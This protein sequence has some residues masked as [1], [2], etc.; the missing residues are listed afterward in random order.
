MWYFVENLGAVLI[1]SSGVENRSGSHH[2][3]CYNEVLGISETTE[4][5]KRCR[6]SIGPRGRDT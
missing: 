4:I 1:G 2:Y 6:I 3:V 5:M